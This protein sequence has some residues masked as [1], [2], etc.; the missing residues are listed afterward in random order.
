[1]KAV[2]IIPARFASS[3]FPGKPLTKLLG[4]SMI[5][6]VAEL[7]EKAVGKEN[8][9]VATDDARIEAEV[10][11]NGFTAIITSAKCL[12]GTDRLAEAAQQIKADI[13]VNVQGDEP[14]INP[15]DINKA[16]ELKKENQSMVINA[17]CKVG[18]GEDPENVNIPKVITTE[19]DR[20]VYM[21]RC[22]IPGN[23]NVS[24]KPQFYKKQ[25][26]IYAFK[27]EELDLY[28][29]YGRK[30]YLE[31]CEDIEILRFLDLNVPVKM[32]ETSAGSLAVDIPEDVFAVEKALREMTEE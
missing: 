8:V 1:M 27:K 19:D 15:N 6:R 10:Q 3:R 22:A 16:I 21:S 17:Y 24:T 26:C 12:T 11:S 18:S 32:F 28:Y 4:K 30:S 31:E 23:K 29:S 7:C 20:L 5:V 9:F 25:V 14:L 13:Y 2:V